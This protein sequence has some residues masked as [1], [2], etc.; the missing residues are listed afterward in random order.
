M[1]VQNTLI[2]LSLMMLIYSYIFGILKLTLAVSGGFTL[3][4][5]FS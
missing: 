2:M 4:S 5:N 1:S 3:Q